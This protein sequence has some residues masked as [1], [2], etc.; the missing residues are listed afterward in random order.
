MVKPTQRGVPVKQTP[1]LNR[2]VEPSSKALMLWITRPF[3]NGTW[4]T[5][6]T[7]RIERQACLFV[8]RVSLAFPFLPLGSNEEASRKGPQLCSGFLDRMN[9]HG[10]QIQILNVLCTMLLRSCVEAFKTP[11]SAA[12]PHISATLKNSLTP[13]VGWPHSHSRLAALKEGTYLHQR[14]SSLSPGPLLWLAGCPLL[15]SVVL[16]RV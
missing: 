1:I 6:A 14:L 9:R 11:S 10:R 7:P 3:S 13:T 5:G 16:L 8:F 15:C 2:Q 4:L 12:H